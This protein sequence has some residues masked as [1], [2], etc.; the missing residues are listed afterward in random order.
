MVLAKVAKKL[1]IVMISENDGPASSSADGSEITECD[2]TTKDVILDEIEL[3][4]KPHPTEMGSDNQILRVLK[5]NSVRYIKTT[6][7]ATS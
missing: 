2:S 6:T 5:E 4:F 7:N 3:V 1:K